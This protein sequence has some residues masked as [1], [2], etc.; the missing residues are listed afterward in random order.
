MRTDYIWMEN[1]FKYLIILFLMTSC[2]RQ[3]MNT[4]S[5]PSHNAQATE[6]HRKEAAKPEPSMMKRKGYVPGQWCE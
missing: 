4:D 6:I 3:G 5:K 2:A 1:I